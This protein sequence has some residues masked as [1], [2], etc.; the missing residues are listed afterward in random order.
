MFKR[1]VLWLTMMLPPQ[2]SDPHPPSR[3]V[4][5]GKGVPCCGASN[6]LWRSC[7]ATSRLLS[8]RSYEV[9]ANEGVTI[10]LLSSISI[11]LWIILSATQHV[12]DR[13][14]GQFARGH[15]FMWQVDLR[16]C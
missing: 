13:R 2:C 4:I 5:R 12:Q 7:Y 14:A 1:F 16:Q 3:C 6:G 10:H 11:R 15:Q 8:Y 9:A